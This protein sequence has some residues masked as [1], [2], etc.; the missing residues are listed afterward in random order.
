MLKTLSKL[1]TPELLH[2]LA[3]M[4]HGDE[5]ALVDSNFPAVSHAQRV[6]RLDGADL[7]STL[8]ACLQLMPLDN[9]VRE[10]AFRMQQVHAPDEIPEV[11]K[12]CQEIVDR[13]EGKHVALTGIS[14]EEFY[15]R[16]RKAFAV[17]ITGEQRPYGCI[18]LKKGV[19]FPVPVQAPFLEQD[20]HILAGAAAGKAAFSV[21]A[22]TNG[23]PSRTHRR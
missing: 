19:V 16:A 18:L 12:D 8:E 23:G 15:E 14:R 20:D 2:T 4:G 11:Q 17:V 9:F 6:V 21:E 1:H 22:E 10:A 7:S 5:I 13:M 3:S